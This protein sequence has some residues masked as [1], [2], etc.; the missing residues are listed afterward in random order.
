[1]KAAHNRKR[2]ETC[3]QSSQSLEGRTLQAADGDLG[4]L[5]ALCFDATNWVIR[6]LL[7]LTN[8]KLG[9]RRVLLLPLAVDDNSV[10]KGALAVE[11]TRDQIEGSPPFDADRPISRAYEARYYAYY[12]WPPYWEIDPL[13]GLPLSQVPASA[14]SP[15]QDSTR[16]YPRQNGLHHSTDL[17]GCEVIACDGSAG[18]VRD[19]VVDP[20]YWL[21]RYLR[22]ETGTGPASR[23]VL[24]GV[25][26]VRQVNWMER[27]VEVNLQC[28]TITHAPRFD[29]SMDIDH[30]FEAQVRKHYGHPPRR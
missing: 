23:D 26:W 5:E 7:V 20:R 12:N 10:H 3:L 8:E 24:L 21:L 16:T 22:I 27:R 13:A 18:I 1:M 19:L 17:Y 14:E 25:P 9:C 29:T 6:Y 15:L 11:L 28:A 30:E 4:V 2:S